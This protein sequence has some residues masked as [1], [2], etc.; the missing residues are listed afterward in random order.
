MGKS[1]LRHGMSSNAHDRKRFQHWLTLY[2]RARQMTDNPPAKDLSD[3]ELICWR[4][5][6]CTEASITKCAACLT[7]MRRA[8]TAAREQHRKKLREM[9]HHERRRWWHDRREAVAKRQTENDEAMLSVD[10]RATLLSL[11]PEIRQLI[12]SLVI[13]NGCASTS[14]Q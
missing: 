4:E 14:N 5:K 1:A 2:T 12:W 11:P 3:V 9:P 10:G 6:E 13:D 8:V 7:K